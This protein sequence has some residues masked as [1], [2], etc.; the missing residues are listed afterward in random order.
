MPFPNEH[1]A[2][3]TDP[4]MYDEFR[5]FTTEGS[6]RGLVDDLRDQRRRI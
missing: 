5:R 3:Q 6:S 2:R 1:A 4:A